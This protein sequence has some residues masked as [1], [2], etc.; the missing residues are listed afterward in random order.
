MKRLLAF[1]VILSGLSFAQEV[2]NNA[3]VYADSV[4]FTNS[5]D[6]D[7][8]HIINLGFDYDWVQITLLKNS[9][10]TVDSLRLTRGI[11]GYN[12]YLGAVDTIWT[13]EIPLKDNSWETLTRAVG[14][15][16]ENKT[17]LFF[18]PV[19]QLVKIELVNYRG[20][21]PTRTC[22]YRLV[23]TKRAK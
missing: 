1:L 17:Y 15:S 16:S 4:N 21:L 22:S 23:A 5:T 11:I 6:S 2:V 14:S 7:S 20:T 19:I 12:K 3:I 10:T 13:N 9:N 8:I 18:D